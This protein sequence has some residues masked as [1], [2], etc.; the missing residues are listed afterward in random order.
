MVLGIGSSA[1]AV[2]HYRASRHG[3]APPYPLFYDLLGAVVFL[4]FGA[5]TCLHL[6]FFTGSGRWWLLLLIPVAALKWRGVLG[7]R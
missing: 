4:A 6:P 7:R 5:G 3:K 2:L 1:G